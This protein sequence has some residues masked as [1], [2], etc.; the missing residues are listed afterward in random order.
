MSTVK[1]PEGPI[2]L[3]AGLS[4]N[5]NAVIQFILAGVPAPVR[6]AVRNAVHNLGMSEKLAAIDLNMAAFRAITAEEEAATALFHSLKRR[7]YANSQRLRLRDH[8]FKNA[9]APFLDGVRTALAQAEQLGTLIVQLKIPAP[10]HSK[11]QPWIEIW[12]PQV[13]VGRRLTPIPPLGFNMSVNDELHDFR[14]EFQKI[15]NSRGI[16]TVEQY[17]R[18]RANQRNRLL[19]ASGDGI[20]RV[21]SLNNFLASQRKRVFQILTAVVFVDPYPD[22]QIF[23]QQCLDAFLKVAVGVQARVPETEALV[24]DCGRRSAPPLMLSISQTKK[25]R[26]R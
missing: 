7:G 13:P 22:H 17:V 20:P 8:R 6:H 25:G 16:D 26:A 1:K 9:V 15:T 12:T 18:E 3:P 10:N 4:S 11:N 23:V 21:E 2:E 24:E 19:Y 5:E 14:E